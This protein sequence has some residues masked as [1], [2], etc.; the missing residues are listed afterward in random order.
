MEQSN[1]TTGEL[2]E[3][4]GEAEA[5]DATSSSLAPTIAGILLANMPSMVSSMVDGAIR[6]AEAH[7]PQELGEFLSDE[8]NII[9]WVG[10]WCARACHPNKDKTRRRAAQAQPCSSIS[11]CTSALP[12]AMR[13]AVSGGAHL[14]MVRAP[15]R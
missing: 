9:I 3:Q 13:A 15:H 2:G 4:L 10:L 11:G 6:L 12:G 1:N 14:A 7:G 5:I 8:A